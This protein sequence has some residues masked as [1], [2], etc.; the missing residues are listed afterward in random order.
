MPHLLTKENEEFTF[1]NSDS[2]LNSWNRCLVFA[3]GV[4]IT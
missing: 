2:I 1:L 3:L 4:V